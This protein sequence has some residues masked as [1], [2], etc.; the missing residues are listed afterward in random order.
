MAARGLVPNFAGIIGEDEEYI[1]FDD[2]TRKPQGG[3]PEP[4]LSGGGGGR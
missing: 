4:A 1:Y 3:A 2:G